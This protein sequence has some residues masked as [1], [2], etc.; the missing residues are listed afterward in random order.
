[1]KKSTKKLAR[2]VIGVACCFSGLAHGQANFTVYGELDVGVARLSN[3]GMNG[4]GAI[5]S[6]Y[7]GLNNPSYIGFKGVESLGNG[8]EAFFV[9]ESGVAVTSGGLANGN[10][11]LWGRLANVGVVGP[12]GSLTAGLQLDPYLLSV[13]LT[14]PRGFSGAGSS[15]NT[16]LGSATYGILNSK[17]GTTPLVGIR[18]SNAI[19]YATPAIGG[20]Q[21]SVLYGLG[22]V[23]GNS[24]AGRR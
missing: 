18:D 17:I 15:I 8:F 14:D 11:N 23:A 24:S 10:G 7:S 20:F 21:A 2:S 1:M 19:S 9:L 12:F 5:T 13:I 22:E 4:N 3:V 6:L 16:Y